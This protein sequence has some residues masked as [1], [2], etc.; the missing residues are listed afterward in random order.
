MLPTMFTA[1]FASHKGW[2]VNE[3]A[4]TCTATTV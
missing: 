1:R 4:F 2:L 3:V